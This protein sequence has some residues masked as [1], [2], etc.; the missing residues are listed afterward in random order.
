MNFIAVMCLQNMVPIQ[1]FE[2]FVDVGSDR[3]EVHGVCAANLVRDLGFV[4]PAVEQVENLGAH[5]VEAEHLT[6]MNVQK[7]S[8]VL[9]PGS[10]DGVSDLE[11]GRAISI[12]IDRSG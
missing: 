12:G 8:A 9:G 4:N 7:D 5:K 10:A 2:E 6:V 3:F 1:D 11:H